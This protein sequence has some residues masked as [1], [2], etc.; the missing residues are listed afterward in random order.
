MTNHL[1]LPEAFHALAA[2]LTTHLE[3]EAPA[4]ITLRPRQLAVQLHSGELHGLV[5][6]A[7]SL[8]LDQATV[9]RGGPRD[10]D[11]AIRS[12]WANLHVH[13]HLPGAGVPVEVWCAVPQLEAG[14][15]ADGSTVTDLGALLQ[16][17]AAV[18]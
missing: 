6:W 16:P 14:D 8:D 11:G 15:L 1:H 2:H 7:T 12:G 9:M 13:G 18:A 4:N 3:L 17:L 5:R 10:D